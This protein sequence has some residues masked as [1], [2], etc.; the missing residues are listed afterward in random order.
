[1]RDETRS[2]PL[3]EDVKAAIRAVKQ[4]LRQQIGDVEGLFRQVCDSIE[5]AIVEA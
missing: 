1:M 5:A 2:T 4:Q 3:P